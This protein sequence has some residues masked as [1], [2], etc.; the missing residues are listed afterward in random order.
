MTEPEPEDFPVEPGASPA[1]FQRMYAHRSEKTG[2]I[3]NVCQSRDELA[4]CTQ[5]RNY[6]PVTWTIQT[7]DWGPLPDGPLPDEIANPV[8][9]ERTAPPDGPA[10]A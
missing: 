5:I 6:R 7:S 9:G 2:N 1:K 8:T 3:I 10:P 4:A